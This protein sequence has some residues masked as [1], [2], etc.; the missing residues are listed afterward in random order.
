MDGDIFDD[1]YLDTLKRG[2]HWFVVHDEI[3]KKRSM[4]VKLDVK[5]EI[6]EYEIKEV[7]K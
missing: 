3:N 6:K 4:K 5:G 2:L 1:T 7:S